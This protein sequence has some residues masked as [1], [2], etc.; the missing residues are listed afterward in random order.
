MRKIRCVELINNRVSICWDKMASEGNE[1]ENELKPNNTNDNLESLKKEVE[2]LKTRLEEERKKLNDVTC[3]ITN[4]SKFIFI[5]IVSC[6]FLSC[7]TIRK[8]N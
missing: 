3:K 8:Y 6:S 5:P 1:N 2:K 7:T 4:Q